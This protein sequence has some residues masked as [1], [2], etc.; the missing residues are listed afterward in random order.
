MAAVGSGIQ[1][2]VAASVV[3]LE[4]SHMQ[5]VPPAFSILPERRQMAV[6]G[7]QPVPAELIV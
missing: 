4:G 6:V 7:L 2:P 1:I 5:A 3:V